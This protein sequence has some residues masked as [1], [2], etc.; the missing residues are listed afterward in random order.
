MLTIENPAPAS[1]SSVVTRISQGFD[2]STEVLRQTRLMEAMK[3][4]YRADQQLKFLHLQAET[5][6]LLQ[7]LQA[8]KQQRQADANEVLVEASPH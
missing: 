7:Q 6:S 5:E 4:Q 1:T 8:I 2:G 3:T